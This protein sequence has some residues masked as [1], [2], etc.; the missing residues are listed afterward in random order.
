M[1][2]VIMTIEFI[3]EEGE[4]VEQNQFFI[5]RDGR[6]CQKVSDTTYFHVLA[7]SVGVPYALEVAHCKI[8]LTKVQKIMP[9]AAKIVWEE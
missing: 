7:A 9:K 1:R 4:D 2:R 3:L 6:L 8:C 5:N